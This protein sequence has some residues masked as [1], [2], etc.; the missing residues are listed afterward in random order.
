MLCAWS[1]VA[2]F[3]ATSK[4]WGVLKTAVVFGKQLKT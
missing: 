3:L 1:D 4:K 2:D